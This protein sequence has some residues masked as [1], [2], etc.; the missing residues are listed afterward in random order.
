[1]KAK[2]SRFQMK[3]PVTGCILDEVPDKG[4]RRLKVPV[5]GSIQVPVEGIQKVSD[6]ASSKKFYIKVPDEGSHKTFQMK[7]SNKRFQVQFQVS[8][9]FQ[10]EN[11][12]KK[13]YETKGVSER[14]SSQKV[15]NEFFTWFQ[16]Q[17]CWAF[18]N[19]LIAKIHDRGQR[20]W[21]GTERFRRWWWEKEQDE[22][23]QEI[24]TA[25]YV[26]FFQSTYFFSFEFLFN[27]HPILIKLTLNCCIYGC[28][29]YLALQLCSSDI[30]GRMQCVPQ[31][32]AWI[33][34][35]CMQPNG[36]NAL[37]WCLPAWQLLCT[38]GIRSKRAGGHQTGQRILETCDL[39][40]Y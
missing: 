8:G 20:H 26:L 18:Y 25:R 13:G 27:S 2:G 6:E 29:V 40:R 28:F 21:C 22:A 7:S 11:G 16:V 5:K 34:R 23:W 39:L 4:R 33:S 31:S 36:P 3:I 10:S 17:S 32:K 38:L 12:S 24:C 35:K 1:M 19:E 30:S 14:V 9:G 37:S 15:L